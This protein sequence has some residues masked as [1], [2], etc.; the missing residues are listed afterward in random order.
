MTG[1]ATRNDRSGMLLRL[2]ATIVVLALAAGA[3][4]CGDD[5]SPTAPSSTPSGVPVIAG[6]WTGTSDVEAAG[7]RHLITRITLS[8]T[9]NDRNVEGT[10][11]FTDST[12][13]GWR[14][15]FS[16]TVSGTVDPE[17]VGLIRLEADSL[18]GT[19]L[20]QGQMTMSGRTTAAS[21]RWDAA[22]LSMTLNTAP[23]EQQACLGTVR[24][25]AWI[26]GR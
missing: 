22:S 11:R 17:F 9:Q 8:V 24:N 21:M 16:G 3:A 25:V 10:I 20:C 5:G 14:G 18:T 13:S 19:G 7:N 12:W 15:T 26:F 4:A 2:T 6:A 1:A 23:T